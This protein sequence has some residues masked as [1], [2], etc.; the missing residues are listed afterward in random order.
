MTICYSSSYG[1]S[2]N[3]SLEITYTSR[4]IW[5]GFDL[6]HNNHSAVQP[7]LT[8]KFGRTGL[9]INIWSSFGINQRTTTKPADELDYVIGYD[10]SL[11]KEL[12]DFSTG[13]I[14]YT[15]PNLTGEN[16][17][18]EI[19]ASLLFPKMT[20]SPSLAVYYDMNL[21]DGLYMIGSIS[22]SLD[23][24]P[25]TLSLSAGF[26]NHQYIKDTGL[27]DIVLSCSYDNIKIRS[28][29]LSASLNYGFIPMDTV[30]DEDEFWVSIRYTF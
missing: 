18:P 24:L 19:F 21:G 4:Y 28:T 23:S 3:L 20:F 14:Y 6:L 17:S 15:Y 27:S 30:N 16:T 1:S 29:S 2:N 25:I 22:K 5:R 8:Y 10:I 7:S 26:N 11:G 13:L 12:I 9:W